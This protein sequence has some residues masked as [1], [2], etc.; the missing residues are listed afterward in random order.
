[1]MIITRTTDVIWWQ[2][3][4]LIHAA[5]WWIINHLFH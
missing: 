5:T 1:M 3:E 2:A 4:S